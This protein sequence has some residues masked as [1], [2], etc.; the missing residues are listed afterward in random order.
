MNKIEEAY[1]PPLMSK[2]IEPTTAEPKGRKER[3]WGRAFIILNAI[4]VALPVLLTAL[5]F[6]INS[7]PFQS[8]TYSDDLDPI[9]YSYV[10]GIGFDPLDLLVYLL[11]PNCI[12]LVVWLIRGR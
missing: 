4:L 8:L 5:V 1:E 3:R 6:V 12:F 11:I 7:Q 9:V 10:V 2:D